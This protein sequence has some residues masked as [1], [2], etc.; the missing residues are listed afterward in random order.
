MSF[1]LLCPA[2]RWPTW[3]L[4]MV[5][6][7]RESLSSMPRTRWARQIAN[8]RASLPPA[9]RYARAFNTLGG[10]NMAEPAFLMGSRRTCSF[11]LPMGT[12]RLSRR[13]SP[14]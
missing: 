13:S 2:L 8:A 9:T 4:I 10:E 11:P 5:L 12:A 1:C 7:W 14:G 6:R 3:W